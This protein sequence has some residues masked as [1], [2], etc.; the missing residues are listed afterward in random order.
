MRGTV[1]V[2][3]TETFAID[4]EGP[5]G[6]DVYEW[7]DPIDAW[8]LTGSMTQWCANSLHGECAILR[9]A[10]T[11]NTRTPRDIP[12][13][14]G[15]DY[16]I[17]PHESSWITVGGFSIRVENVSDGVKVGAYI[18]NHENDTPLGELFFRDSGF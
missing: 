9:D 13:E 11:P 17:A 4:P 10:P 6:V 1:F 12:L 14:D 18:V 2:Q 5:L 3:R 7:N 8:T 16:E 15:A